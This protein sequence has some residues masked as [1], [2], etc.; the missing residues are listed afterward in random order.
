MF[1]YHKGL[2]LEVF[3]PHLEEPT[4]GTLEKAGKVPSPSPS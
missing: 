2:I 3:R 1:K 4:Q